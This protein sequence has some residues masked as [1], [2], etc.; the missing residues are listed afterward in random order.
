[1]FLFGDKR[2]LDYQVEVMSRQVKEVNEIYMTMRGWRHDY[3]N[4]LQKLKGHL[5]MGQ[6][7]EAKRYL[8]ELE[9]ELDGIRVKY[10]TGNVSLDAIL[11]SKLSI[12]EK[13]KIGINCKAEIG[14]NLTIGDI[15]LCV[16][17]GNLIDNAVESCRKMPEDAERFLRIYVCIRKRQL[18]IAVT[19][20]TGEVIRKLD[21]EYISNKRGDHG[22]GLKRVDLIV[23]KYNG[24]IRR[25]NEPG[26]FSAEIM[27][28]L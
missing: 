9:G 25:A 14:E 1:M 20:S 12:A 3:H 21:A 4:H 5:A 15:D 18:Y 23:D 27:L 11:N 28:P 22:H 8:N 7:E 6:I 16:I 24:Y 10:S 19:N 2:Y 17:L 13:E 26:V